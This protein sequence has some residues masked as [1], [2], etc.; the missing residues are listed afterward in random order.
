MAIQELQHPR[1][2][3][4]RTPSL[5]FPFGARLKAVMVVSFQIICPQTLEIIS[6]SHAPQNYIGI[7][8]TA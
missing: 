3:I 1:T 2:L 6:Y 4:S 5:I 7:L 8:L